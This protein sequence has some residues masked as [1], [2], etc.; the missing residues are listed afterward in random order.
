MD[1]MKLGHPKGGK[2]KILIALCCILI[3]LWQADV[4][5]FEVNVH[6]KITKEAIESNKANLDSYLDNIGLHKGILER[7]DGKW[8]RQWIE[9]GSRQE[10]EPLLDFRYLNHFYNPLDGKGLHD[11]IFTGKSSYEWASSDQ[12]NLWSWAM[13]RYYY[14]VGLVAQAPDHRANFLSKAFRSLG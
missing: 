10:D 6:E 11:G 2:M 8:I 5:A 1:M 9:E 14:Y 4:N 7:V 13:L 3:S 12:G